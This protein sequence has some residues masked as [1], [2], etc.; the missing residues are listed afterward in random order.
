[1][2]EHKPGF[3]IKIVSERTG[4]SVHTLRAWER[5]YG[6]PQPRRNVENRYRLYDE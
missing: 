3:N 4:V 2:R 5:R 6:I 1:M